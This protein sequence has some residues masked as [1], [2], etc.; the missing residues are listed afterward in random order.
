L[1]Q[2]ARGLRAEGLGASEIAQV[3]SDALADMTGRAAVLAAAALAGVR[4]PAS[5]PPSASRSS[6]AAAD[7]AGCPFGPTHAPLTCDGS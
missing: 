7:L 5:R 3:I 4:A 6:K 2:L 1:P